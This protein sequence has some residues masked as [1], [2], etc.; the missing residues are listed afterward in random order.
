MTR[1]RQVE[2]NI[3]NVANVGN[4]G[5]GGDAE[6]PLSMPTDK[7]QLQNYDNVF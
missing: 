7:L 5:K 4:V 3:S 6:V 2:S 1:V